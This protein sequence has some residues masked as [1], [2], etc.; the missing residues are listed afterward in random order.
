MVCNLFT[1][2]TFAREYQE[3]VR[4]QAF[5]FTYELCQDDSLLAGLNPS[6]MEK[7]FSSAFLLESDNQDLSEGDGYLQSLKDIFQ[8]N[9]FVAELVT[10]PGFHKALTDC[11]GND[12]TKRKY[13]L[14][15]V[16]GSDFLGRVTGT[17]SSIVPYAL[18]RKGLLYAFP[19][20][21]MKI[22]RF[23][24]R[25][26]LAVGV[27][28]GGSI[29]YDY[30]DENNLTKEEFNESLSFNN[31]NDLI[32]K[33]K[34]PELIL[35]AKIRNI[36]KLKRYELIPNLEK[37]ILSLDEIPESLKQKLC[38]IQDI[39]YSFLLDHLNCRSFKL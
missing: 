4:A 38:R 33:K 17:I 28:V 24:E 9:P 29:S 15:K 18:I 25:S 22:V 35:N 5:E 1:S 30:Y 36:L 37:Q 10:S 3:R 11:Y 32:I 39:Q 23:F 20:T 31:D 6:I 16:F 8:I 19:K 34:L 21:G 2:N 13:F 14:Y 7:S 26:L 12:S 27:A